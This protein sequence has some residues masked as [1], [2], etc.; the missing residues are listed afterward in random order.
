ML[1]PRR[2]EPELGPGPVPI[3]ARKVDFDVS[4]VQLH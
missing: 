3:Q 2:F 4:G 1:R